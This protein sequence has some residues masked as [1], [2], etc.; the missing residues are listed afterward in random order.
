LLS[1]WPD[2]FLGYSFFDALTNDEKVVMVVQFYRQAMI[3]RRMLMSPPVFWVGKSLLIQGIHGLPRGDYLFGR[4]AAIE[5][6]SG[7]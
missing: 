7:H 1:V 3:T 4:D 6:L 2:G 5:P